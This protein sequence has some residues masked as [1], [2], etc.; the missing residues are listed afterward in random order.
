MSILAINPSEVGDLISTLDKIWQAL[1]VGVVVKYTFGASVLAVAVFGC[2]LVLRN[3][4]KKK[5]QKND[6]SPGTTAEV[7]MEQ[8]PPDSAPGDTHQASSSPG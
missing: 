1:A 5:Q 3:Q 7:R 2:Y 8:V 4:Q 6:S